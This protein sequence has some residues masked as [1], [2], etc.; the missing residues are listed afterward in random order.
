MY[1]I[2]KKETNKYVLM[3]LDYVEGMEF[4]NIWLKTQIAS[5]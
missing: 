3:K 2:Q 5:K 1:V 4:Y